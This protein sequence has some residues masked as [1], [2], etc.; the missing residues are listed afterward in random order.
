MDEPENGVVRAV[1][2]GSS[3]GVTMEVTMEPTVEVTVTVVSPTPGQVEGVRQVGVERGKFAAVWDVGEPGG[4][5]EIWGEK[6]ARE[7]REEKAQNEACEEER[8]LIHVWATWVWLHQKTLSGCE[9]AMWKQW[10]R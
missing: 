7:R 6:E 1:M 10:A 2:L 3:A 8:Q 9:E 4:W 5:G